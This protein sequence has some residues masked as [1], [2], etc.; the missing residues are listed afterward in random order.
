MPDLDTASRDQRAGSIGRGVAVT[1]LGGFD[2]SV[3]GEVATGNEADHVLAV[4]V[5]PVIQLV[6]STT[7]GS[8]R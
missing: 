7:R 8:T 4:F 3:G 2:G 1:N 5:A 6:P